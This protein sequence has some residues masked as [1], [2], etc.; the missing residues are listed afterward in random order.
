[1]ARF[2]A[3]FQGLL[4]FDGRLS[5][6]EFWRAYLWLAVV[7]SVAIVIGLMAILALGAWGG[8]FLLPVAAVLVASIAIIVRRLHD[9]NKSGLWVLAFVLFP[10]L[11]G[12]WVATEEGRRAAPAALAALSLASLVLNI[13]GLIEIGFRRGRP[14][15][16]RFGEA[17]V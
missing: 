11:V 8:V 13:W 7:G 15:A 1:M 9:R 5:R 16:N 2:V 6:I 4:R 10:T 17:P 12:L 14:A 3:R